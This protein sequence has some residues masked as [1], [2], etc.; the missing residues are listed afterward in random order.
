MKRILTVFWLLVLVLS[1][2]DYAACA[3]FCRK[4][5]RF[6]MNR[7]VRESDAAVVFFGDND[8]EYHMGP[9]TLRRA[10]HA[11]ELY[12]KESIRAIICVGG[13]NLVKKRGISGAQMMR[14]YFTENGVPGECVL[15]D[16]V[17]YDSFSNWNEAYAMI[18]S[19]GWKRIVLVS[20]PLHLYRLSRFTGDGTLDLFYSPWSPD[21]S[22]TLKNYRYLRGWIHHEWL[23]YTAFA[24]LPEPY[25][26]KALFV[27]RTW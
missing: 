26:R 13:G 16:T 20:S 19:H 14:N 11:L 23:A 10:E 9:E 7:E 17:S 3:L 18:V 27:I 5:N 15:Y 24:V 22:L 12:R 6:F 8:H 4:V 2:M 1:G 25:Y 21:C